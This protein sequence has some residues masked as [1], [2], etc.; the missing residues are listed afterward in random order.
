MQRM[1]FGFEELSNDLPRPPVAAQRALGAAGV[2]MPLAAWKALSPQTRLGLAYAGAADVVDREAVLSLLRGGAL[3]KVQLTH[4]AAEPSPAAPPRELEKVLGPWQRVVKHHWPSMRGLHRYL[5]ALLVGNPRLLWRALNEVA[6]E[7]GWH[8]S[9]ALPPMHGLLAR[10]DVRVSTQWFSV[11]EDPRFHAGR[12]G[13]LARAAGVRAARWMS[14][15]LDAHA[16][17]VVGPVELEW[18]PLHGVGVV[19]QAHVS[20]VQGVFSPAGSLLAAT[21]AAVALVDLLREIDPAAKIVNAAISDEP[22]LFG[23]VG[24]ESTLAF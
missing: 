2:S 22:W 11:L 21:T 6:S 8:G 12:A 10:C 9:E 5:L 3:G 24:S 13:V 4:P 17:G 19:W 18:G 1:V 20:T 23:A 16:D 14:E 7:G 15:L